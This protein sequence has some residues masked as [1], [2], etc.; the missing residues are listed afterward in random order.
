M[1]G[2]VFPDR[3][4]FRY[5]WLAFLREEVSEEDLQ[6]T[7]KTN[8]GNLSLVSFLFNPLNG[9][10]ASPT[11]AS[12]KDPYSALRFICL[13]SGELFFPARL[14]FWWFDKRKK[15]DGDAR[16]DVFEFGS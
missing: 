6:S 10:F 13:P 4:R 11:N 1:L 8:A 15:R 7:L 9:F 2:L 16:N 5:T 14:A 3:Y 12:S